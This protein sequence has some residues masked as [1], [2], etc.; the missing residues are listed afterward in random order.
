MTAR[1]L[2][3]QALFSRAPSLFFTWLPY[4]E[5]QNA[6]SWVLKWAHH[7]PPHWALIH[8]ALYQMGGDLAFHQV[9]DS[10]NP[11]Q[12]GS[13]GWGLFHGPIL[14]TSTWYHDDLGHHRYSRC[15]KIQI[16]G[17]IFTSLLKVTFLIL[18]ASFVSSSFLSQAKTFFF[19]FSCTME[20]VLFF[21]SY[22]LCNS[23]PWS[24]P[25]S[26]FLPFPW[27]LEIEA[28]ISVER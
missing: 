5:H 1:A 6:L 9:I 13:R 8:A 2:E 4:L 3:L 25:H 24:C 17:H 12:L 26:I 22:T 19:L 10:P 7:L 18:V 27:F 14:P 15:P 28:S 16:Q 21:L 11:H 20:Y 23:C